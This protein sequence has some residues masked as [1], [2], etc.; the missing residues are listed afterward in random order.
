MTIQNNDF[1]VDTTHKGFRV[2]KITPLPALRATAY[3][4]EHAASGA[5]LLH[6]H[7]EDIENCFAVTFPTPTPP[8]D[9]TG[10]P[11]IL[12]HSVLA[13]SKKHP[14]FEPFFEM[15]KISMA[16]FINALTS[17][18]FTVYP[19]ATTVKKGFFNLADGYMDAIFHPNITESTFRAE[20]HHYTLADNNDL[21]SDLKISG[22]V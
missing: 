14:V 11:H 13:G 8:L 4:M 3:E 9:E 22:I 20:G 1:T 7:T 19:I 10:I 17:Q 5:R 16:T 21:S 2:I 18:M 15:V 6:L 12:E